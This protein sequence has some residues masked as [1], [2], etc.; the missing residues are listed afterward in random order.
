MDGILE[1]ALEDQRQLAGWPVRIF[2]V[3]LSIASWTMSSAASSFRTAYMACLNA[4]RSTAARKARFPD[5]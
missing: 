5:G 3:S 2:S 1:D 4:R